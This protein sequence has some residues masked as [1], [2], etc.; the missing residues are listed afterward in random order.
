[1]RILR[2]V[3]F[4]KVAFELYEINTENRK[5]ANS[6][7]WRKGKCGN[8]CLCMYILQKVVSLSLIH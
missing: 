7:S 4:S 2:T 3:A 8:V 5:R 1:M 6:N